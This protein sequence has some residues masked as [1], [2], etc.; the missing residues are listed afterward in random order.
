MDLDKVFHRVDI[1]L[2]DR[3]AV[4]ANFD[5]PQ[6]RACCYPTAARA[7]GEGKEKELLAPLEKEPNTWVP[8]EV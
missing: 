2:E 5:P 1:E 6:A 8:T 3:P 4:K 7:E